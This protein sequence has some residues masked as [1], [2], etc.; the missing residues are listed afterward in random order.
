MTENQTETVEVP[1]TL[2]ALPEE[3]HVSLDLETLCRRPGGVI[4][5][6][7]ATVF[8][9]QTGRI[10]EDSFYAVLS[11]REQIRAGCTVDPDTVAWWM[12][13]SDEAKNEVYMSLRDEYADKLTPVPGVLAAFADWCYSKAERVIMWG[14]GPDFDNAMLQSLYDRVGL[15]APWEYWNSDSVR[16]IARTAKP[17]GWTKPPRAGTHHHALH[18]S[19]YQAEVVCSAN[20]HIRK[21]AYDSGSLPPDAT[22]GGTIY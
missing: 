3:A 11:A 16:T 15:R 2:D 7:G 17:L 10:D 21:L 5:T 9:P 8:D 1:D 20:G 6:I 18:D 22:P 13:Q 14:N 12:E 4:L 19:R